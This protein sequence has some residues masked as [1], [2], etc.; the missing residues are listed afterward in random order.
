MIEIISKGSGLSLQDYGR[1]G[2]RRFG[3]PSGG[4]MDVR[5]MDLANWL[6]GNP[7]GSTVLEITLLGARLRVLEDTWIAL[8]GADFCGRLSTGTAVPLHAG[9]ELDFDQKSAGLYAYLAVP[10]GFIADA[11]LGSA[12]ADPRNGLGRVLRKTDRLL[13]R[14]RQPNISTQGVARRITSQPLNHIPE[15]KVHFKL[16]PGTQDEAFAAKT[17]KAFIEQVWTISPRS[18]RTGYRLEGTNLSV[19]ESIPSE[20]VLPGS[21]Q[22]PG[23]GQPIIT[24]HDGPTVGGYPKIAVLPADD[25]DRFAQCAPGTPITFS[26]ID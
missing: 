23:E 1:P 24:M 21:F 15:N 13:A 25:L 22:V 19:P 9:E 8:A 6:L 26:W 2:W 3:V 7:T 18:D 20:P 11:W 14:Q 5:S 10:G 12:S 17:R 16:Y 4:A